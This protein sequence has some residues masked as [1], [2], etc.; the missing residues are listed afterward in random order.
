[1]AT[2]SRALRGLPNVAP[3][4]RL[5]VLEVAK[6]LNYRADPHASRLAAGKTFSVGM[7]VPQLGRWYFSQVI[8]GARDAFAAAGY[9]LLLFA[10]GS[11]AERARF[12]HEWAVLEK[13]VDGLLLVDLRLDPDELEAVRTARTKVVSVGDQYEGFPSV[14]VDNKAAASVA[15]RHLINLGHETIGYIGDGPGPLPFSV[16]NDR[17]AG[18]EQALR[19]ANLVPLAD[20]EASGGFTVEG[21]HRAMTQ[22]LTARTRPTAVFVCSDEMAMGAVKAVR[23][24]GLRVPQDI[25]VI[26]FDDHDLSEIIDLTTIRQ[27]VVD[28]GRVAGQLLIDAIAGDTSAPHHVLPTELVLRKTTGPYGGRAD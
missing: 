1:M 19:E 28:S 20:L 2:V 22:L 3:D 17:R 9:D 21:G 6:K 24:H 13:R 25:S 5:K 10:L 18:W 26:G 27:P 23:E 16:P 8:S 15:V 7:A 11:G 14:T 4:T 12:I